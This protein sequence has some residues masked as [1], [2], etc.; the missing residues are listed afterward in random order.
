MVD[1]L[2]LKAV[3]QSYGKLVSCTMYD[4]QQL[5]MWDFLSSKLHGNTTQPSNVLLKVLET[6][7]RYFLICNKYAKFRNIKALKE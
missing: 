5:K 3:R 6:L 2:L 7:E 1:L 4:A